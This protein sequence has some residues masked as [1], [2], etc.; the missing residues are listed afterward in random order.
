[1]CFQKIVEFPH[2]HEAPLIMELKR[3]LLFRVTVEG[4]SD[5][6]EIYIYSGKPRKLDQF[7]A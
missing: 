5:T 4:E 1:M 3:L 7:P 6:T 2:S